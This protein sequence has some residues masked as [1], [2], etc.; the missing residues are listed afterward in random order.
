MLCGQLHSGKGQEV[1]EQQLKEVLHSLVKL[2]FSK[3]QD[4]FQVHSSDFGS[5]SL[6]SCF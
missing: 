3:S 2:M 5:L 4:L 6:I 1:F